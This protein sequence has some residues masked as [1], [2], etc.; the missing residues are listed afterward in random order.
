MYSQKSVFRKAVK[1]FSNTEISKD[2]I[3]Q[4]DALNEVE[5]NLIE[6]EFFA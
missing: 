6:R 2:S 1:A 3:Q 4:N 5:L